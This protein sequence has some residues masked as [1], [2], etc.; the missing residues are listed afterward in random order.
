VTNDPAALYAALLS[1]RK[2]NSASFERNNSRF[3]YA[4]LA[5][6]VSAAVVAWLALSRGFSILWIL[7]PVCAFVA[8]MMTHERLL[9][10]LQRLRRAEAFFERGLARTHGDWE[11]RGETGER[12]LDPAH[13]YA[14]DLDLFGKASLFEMLSAARTHI[15]EATLAK[16]LLAPET[17]ERVRARQAAVEELRAR[18]DLRE[19][20]AV[21]AEDA[22]TGVDPASLA[23]WGEAPPRLA[24]RSL[25]VSAWALRILGIAGLAAGFVSMIAAAGFVKISPSAVVFGRDLFLLALAVN[26]IFYYRNRAPMEAVVAA[27]DEAA[28]ELRL[29]AEVLALLEKQSFRAPLLVE[30]RASLET[31]HTPPSVRLARLGRLMDYLDSRE[32]IFVKLM[33]PFVLWTP[34]WA[35]QVEEWRKQSGP[36]VRR[37]LE[38]M[39]EME[40]LSSIAGHAFEHPA[41][42]FPE[43]A[44]EGQCFEAEG[45]AH[46]LI[47]EGR[48]VRNDLEIGGELRIVVVSGSNMSGKS[49]LLRTV[50]VNTVLALMGAPV[51]ARRMRLSPLAVGASI[52]LNDSLR[53][54]RSRF[55]AE[56]LRLRQILDLTAGRLPVLFLIDEFMHGTNSHDRRIGAEAMARGL[57]RRGAI[58][59]I[60]THDLALA[61]I[62]DELGP[63]AANVHFEDS[64]ENGEIHFD[65]RMRPG[66]VRKS[67]AVELMRSVG[68]E[69]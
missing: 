48:A 37:W 14:Q 15:G 54:G 63:K 29:V 7:I 60:T 44:E 45:V 28:H 3:A 19:Q 1:E 56:I 62:A 10:R 11:G 68:L 41:D 69:V 59:L 52:R 66:V 13:P 43:L 46:P 65:Y 33:E 31:E 9:R 2:Q 23:Q 17:P 4:R 8:L 5:I 6:A 16:W 34:Y 39:G 25:R 51:R 61:A 32:N 20:L 67:N 26:G 35:I 12:Y 22:R 47:P 27:V 49:T 64:V 30:L 38:A 24:S 18:I 55:Y 53:E 42:P 58:G 40:A 36:A 57:V 21:L 50:G